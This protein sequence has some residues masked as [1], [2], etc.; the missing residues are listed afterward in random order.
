MPVGTQLTECQL[1]WLLRQSW[2]GWGPQ[3]P[4]S[5]HSQERK[6][7][8]R[9][10]SYYFLSN[11]FC[12]TFLKPKFSYHINFSCPDG[13]TL[14]FTRETSKKSQE[15]HRARRRLVHERIWKALQW[16]EGVGREKPILR[17]LLVITVPLQ[18]APVSPALYIIYLN[19]CLMTWQCPHHDGN[20]QKRCIIIKC[21]I[22]YCVWKCP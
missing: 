21:K 22:V 16:G 5:M 19:G 20:F 6:R 10:I 3:A 9:S 15:L 1:F 12:N 2:W 17:T 8:T 11:C 13:G 4:Q 7:G 14:C 18:G